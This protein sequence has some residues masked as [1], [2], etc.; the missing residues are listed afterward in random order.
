M[1]QTKQGEP[2][3]FQVGVDGF[4]PVDCMRIQEPGETLSSQVDVGVK[5]ETTGTTI[6]VVVDSH[7]QLIVLATDETTMTQVSHR[8]IKCQFR[9][10]SQR[11]TKVNGSHHGD[12]LLLRPTGIK[13]TTKSYATLQATPSTNIETV[14]RTPLLH[15]ESNLNRLGFLSPT[16]DQRSQQQTV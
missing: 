6:V 1:Q 13:I 12:N 8:P 15:I 4:L 16:H 5:P 2:S 7:V 9:L 11:G 14:H 10:W 3:P